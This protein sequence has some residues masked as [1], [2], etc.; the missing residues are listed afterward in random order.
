MSNIATEAEA[1]TDEIEGTLERYKICG[2]AITRRVSLTILGLLFL[3][4]FAVGIGFG[5]SV[6]I[7]NKKAAQR[8]TVDITGNRYEELMTLLSPLTDSSIEQEGTNANRALNW[9]A[10]N[11]PAN[12]PIEVTPANE[13]L[14]R[15][16]MA[17]FFQSTGGYQWLNQYNFLSAGNVC[18]WGESKNG[19]NYGVY[20]ADGKHVSQLNVPSNNLTGTIPIDIGLLSSLE[21]FYVPGNFLQGS[22][23][24]T[25]GMMSK[26]REIDFRKCISLLVF[27]LFLNC[28]LFPSA[29]TI[30]ALFRQQPTPI[31]AI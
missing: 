19:S 17:E 5:A 4:V 11:D 15:F 9:L 26:L 23:P 18:E 24:T 2:V 27:F 16:I 20:C 3:S 30:D 12:L 1:F 6:A 22:L 25:I 8:P 29:L 14:V 31:Y 21:F 7:S 28:F 10:N 13:F